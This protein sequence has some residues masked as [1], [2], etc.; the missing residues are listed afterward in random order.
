MEL[1]PVGDVQAI[2]RLLGEVIAM[3]GALQDRKR[4]LVQGLSRL[5]DADVWMWVHSRSFLPG[6]DP[7]PFAVIDGGYA[8]DEQNRLFFQCVTRPEGHFVTRPVIEQAAALGHVTRTRRDIVP[9]DKAWY[10]SVIY[11]EARGPSGL[12][13]MIVSI[14]PIG[15]GV[16][17]AFGFHKRQGAAPF[18]DRERCIV[19]LVL[20]EIDWLHRAGTDVPAAR[21]ADA[22][23]PRQVDILMLLLTGDGPKQIARK[24]ALSV[25]TVNDHMKALHKRFQVN[26]R[27]ELL[28]KF[29]SGGGAPG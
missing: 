21:L 10:E 9:D 3:Q 24:L 18:G 20:S 6:H 23:T 1:L 27:G 17:S 8:N 22:L 15:D 12:D 28:S 13:D 25:H 4:H 26:T 19:H 11:C 5:I 14:Y 29:V 7:V 16:V 2:V